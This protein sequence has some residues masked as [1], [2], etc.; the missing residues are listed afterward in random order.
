MTKPHSPQGGSAFDRHPRRALYEQFARS[1]PKRI[2]ACGRVPISA[3]NRSVRFAVDLALAQASASIGT[4]TRQQ[5]RANK[6]P[7]KKR[8]QQ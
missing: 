8:G 3:Q 2:L 5:E 1:L 4:Y 6:R 7:W